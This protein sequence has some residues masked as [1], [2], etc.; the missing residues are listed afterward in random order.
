MKKLKVMNT[1]EMEYYMYPDGVNSLDGFMGTLQKNN[2]RFVKLKYLNND[3]ETAP[4][5]VQED[6]KD[7]YV[8][9]NNISTVEE[10]EVFLLTDEE[11]EE[12]ME[13]FTDR[14]CAGC[15]FDG[16]PETGCDRI[17][18]KRDKINIIEENCFLYADGYEY[19]EESPGDDPEEGKILRF[20]RDDED[21]D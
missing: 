21:D 11:F 2:S 18:T 12:R 5:F 7:I 13:P 4:N 15:I 6:I 20:T 10:T 3:A 16:N 19:S 9:F 1:S 8:N 17:L 14:I